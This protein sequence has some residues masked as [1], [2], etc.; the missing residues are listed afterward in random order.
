MVRGGEKREEAEL[1]YSVINVRIRQSLGAN[2]RWHW[3][4]NWSG[5]MMNSPNYLDPM[6]PRMQIG[7]GRSPSGPVQRRIKRAVMST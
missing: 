2:W 4:A 1:L 5:V 6:P 7:G 3:G